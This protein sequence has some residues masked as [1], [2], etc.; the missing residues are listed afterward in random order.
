[1]MVN[2]GTASKLSVH[3]YIG[4]HQS[5]ESGAEKGGARLQSCVVLSMCRSGDR[6]QLELYEA[7]LAL[8]AS[9]VLVTA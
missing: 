5:R 3:A 4:K 7:D 6:R 9:S 2:S 1:M 8:S